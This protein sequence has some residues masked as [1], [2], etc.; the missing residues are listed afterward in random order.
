MS[1]HD[2][3]EVPGDEL[4]NRLG[5]TMDLKVAEVLQDWMKRKESNTAESPAEL[6]AELVA[7]HPDLQPQL[8]RCIESISVLDNSE[9]SQSA[10]L[11]PMGPLPDLQI[12]D[13]RIA[14]LLG[15]G[16]MGVV[17]E[18]VQESLERTVALKILPQTSVDPMAAQRFK[19]E[20][21]TAAAL[22]HPNIV[23]VY[24]V[25]HH[26]G[27]HWYAMQRIIGQPLS[28]MLNDFPDGVAIDEVIRIGIES[29]GALDY[30]H[31]KGVMHRDI[32]PGN[33]L[34][35]DDGH[36]WL[37]D[38]GLARRAADV[39]ATVTGAMLGTPRYMSP[40]T[41]FQS[42]GSVPDQRSD[43]YSL[44]ATLYE[45]VTG[46]AL[47]DG[48]TPLDVLQQI[49]M[50]DPPN[51]AAIR[52]ELPRDLEVVLQKCLAKDPADRYQS[53]EA[54]RSDLIAIR[55]GL[56]IKARGVPFWTVAKRR[57]QRNSERLRWAAVAV[58]G[59]LFIGAILYALFQQNRT[60]KLGELQIA[61][62]G[63]PFTTTAYRV[64]E[65]GVADTPQL[66]T[67]VPMQSEAEL[68]AG[69]YEFRFAQHG[70]FSETARAAVNAN[71]S[72]R[73][74]YVDRRNSRD[75]ISIADKYLET[76]LSR[77]G[78]EWLATLDA[79]EFKVFGATETE[80][81]SIATS[82][83]DTD[84]D[85][86]FLA[87]DG[88]TNNSV[89]RNPYYA[90]P[91]RVMTQPLSIKG[92]D[93]FVV[94]ARTSA[95][96]A[97]VNQKGSVSWST[98]LDLP[99]QINPGKPAR[100]TASPVE[101]PAIMEV[102]LL[103]DRDADGTD[104]LLV[105]LTRNNPDLSLDPF[106]VTVSGATGETIAI[107]KLPS[108]DLKLTKTIP[109]RKKFWPTDGSLVHI[110]PGNDIRPFQNLNS[111]VDGVLRRS[112]IKWEHPIHWAGRTSSATVPMIPPVKI[113]R[114]EDQTL[115]VTVSATTMDLWDV[116]NGR[117]VGKPITLPFT[118][119]ASP[120]VIRRGDGSPPA[121]CVW[122]QTTDSGKTIG[123]IAVVSPISSDASASPGI[124]WKNQRPVRWSRLSNGFERTGFPMVTDLDGDGMDEL[125]IADDNDNRDTKA[126][127]ICLDA[128]DGKARW[129]RPKTIHCLASIAERA[130][131]LRDFDNDGFRDIAIASVHGRRATQA[132]RT[133]VFQRS[134]FSLFVDL[135]SGKSGESIRFWQE[136]IATTSKN[137]VTSEVDH[138]VSDGA[139]VIEVSVTT[140]VLKDVSRQSSTIRLDVTRDSPPE[141][142]QGVT[143]LNINNGI[144]SGFYRQRPGADGLYDDRA[145]WIESER[146]SRIRS[147]AHV[148][149]ATWT[150][151]REQSLMLVREN[152]SSMMKAVDVVT[153]KERW[154]HLATNK[155][156]AEPVLDQ[157]GRAN[158]VVV[159]P[160]SKEE[161]PRILDAK[162]GRMICTIEQP[163]GVPQDV[164]V[165][166]GD[167]SSIWILA[168]ASFNGQTQF[169]L[170]GMLLICVDAS[171]GATR[172][173]KQFCR[174]LNPRSHLSYGEIRVL[175][176]DCNGDGVIDAIVPDGDARA[177][178]ELV[179]ISGVDGETLW[180]VTT[181]LAVD[182]WEA[183]SS[184]PP[185][186]NGGPPSDQRIVFFDGNSKAQGTHSVKML[187]AINGAQIDEQPIVVDK[188]YRRSVTQFARLEVGI[189]NPKA[190]WPR[191]SVA[192]P[193]SRGVKAWREFEMGLEKLTPSSRPVVEQKGIRSYHQRI[194]VD[195][196]GVAEHLQLNEKVLACRDDSG[197]RWSVDTSGWNQ[198]DRIHQ[199]PH[200]KPLLG[201]F[202]K[203]DVYRLVS[204]SDGKTV[205]TSPRRQRDAKEQR[206]LRA[207]TPVLLAT[208][209]YTSLVRMTGEGARGIQIESN[210]EPRKLSQSTSVTD[211]RIRR[212]LEG[213]LIYDDRSALSILGTLV[214]SSFLSLFAVVVPAFYV[215]RGIRRRRFT[216]AY[217][218]I[219][220]LVAAATLLTWRYLLSPVRLE[221][222]NI[223]IRQHWGLV[224]TG[225]C[226]SIAFVVYF[227]RAVADGKWMGIGMAF[228][229]AASM[230]LP[231]LAGPILST[232]F[233]KQD[234]TYD[235][236]VS[237]MATMFLMTFAFLFTMMSIQFQ[238]VAPLW[239]RMA[240]IS[241]GPSA[242]EMVSR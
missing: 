54:L 80:V 107:A 117:R 108:P 128:A 160:L 231:T 130:T 7:K 206:W 240:R 179:A 197:E 103:D 64:E 17:Y 92:V 65:A 94:T 59:T 102:L 145:F 241:T 176:M 18:A 195:S 20:A 37:T 146:P 67:T 149:L 230:M 25:G 189:V 14:G 184:W 209:Q 122:S 164:Q 113:V 114:W 162:T 151:D 222:E 140:G 91:R 186:V 57:I 55:D 123:S 181:D 188:T 44:G 207:S 155:A 52:R 193:R 137:V 6:P 84:V 232:V 118:I 21:E 134:D 24:G 34:M 131:V 183:G 224:V 56:P 121:F 150:D 238:L 58:A 167:P 93:H 190:Q 72:S 36:I 4:P 76:L 136:P 97:V 144:A 228:F 168:H 201:V 202:D 174:A 173:R 106:L 124:L 39:T 3:A 212:R 169:G 88:W 192:Y 178:V 196:D 40:E 180:K 38:F 51:P 16:G 216:L 227:W 111:T 185:M 175:H 9:F 48:P 63:G 161:S 98:R 62:A 49:R 42:S 13:F 53:A 214:R 139:D 26:Q 101:L 12:P 32:K 110:S 234:V 135:V 112:G 69:E 225:G 208:S 211:P 73:P 70:R 71:R 177:P 233:E 229:F 96:L 213:S 200:R 142:A 143:R 95:S 61:A 47:F 33:F 129:S 19:R 41:V 127:V 83:I 147:D 191:V 85:Y 35:S 66:T 81:L 15:R 210:D 104:D 235:W 109:L 221:S 157:E 30:A 27:V 8:G 29:A 159:Q 187:S 158:R 45:L 22:H 74:R 100:Q 79:D 46:A 223:D 23:P 75:G 194:D 90:K 170:R 239:K 217:L 141:I 215:L 242:T 10:P 82:Q 156:V 68:P 133:S 199:L 138:L 89:A 60:S 99:P 132:L 203:N 172:W 218:M 163:F 219:A 171:T 154:K 78:H 226:F 116:S 148:V 5:S 165:C 166:D 126:S 220:P 11:S 28:Q 125:L 50:A 115:A 237:G 120:V 204:L 119:A 1:P 182:R 236:S 77:D 86:S 43:I 87:N 152:D 153:G 105:N 198:F 205:W 31:E 2:P